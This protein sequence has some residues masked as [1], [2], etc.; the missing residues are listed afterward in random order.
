MG[1]DSKI[2]LLKQ[3]GSIIDLLTESVLDGARRMQGMA[4]K[5]EVDAFLAQYS[6]ERIED[7]R[8]RIV[9]PGNHP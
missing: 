3:L 4:L 2:T 6:E 7:G 5:K 9:R 8:A 1:D